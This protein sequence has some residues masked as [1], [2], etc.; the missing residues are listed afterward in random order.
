[1]T[2]PP[3]DP[4]FIPLGHVTRPHGV[5]GAFIILP[6]TENAASIL[7]GR[8]LKLMSPE[9]DIRPINSLKGKEAA[10]GLIVKIDG[11]KGRDEAR[12]LAGWSIGLYRDD[13]PPLGEDEIY[14]ADLLGLTVYTKEGEEPLGRVARLMD[15]GAGLLLVIVPPEDQEREIF[16]PFNEEFVISVDL[17]EGRLLIDPPAGL[18][19]L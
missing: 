6:Y 1:M 5:H 2:S 8:H 15:A 18:L 16:M 17:P 11:L 3:P 4:S 9:G 13:L 10:Q 14:W 12:K 19:D 7:K